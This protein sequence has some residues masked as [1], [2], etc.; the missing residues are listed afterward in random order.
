VLWVIF[1]ATWLPFSAF[2]PQV[3]MALA[4]AWA[5]CQA[6]AAPK[7]CVPPVTMATLFSI[8][9]ILWLLL[10][11]GKTLGI[12]KRRMFQTFNPKDKI[13]ITKS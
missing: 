11:F 2:R 5:N 9:F 7:P 8:L 13:C 6:I 3:R 4:P 12:E 1:V 10:L